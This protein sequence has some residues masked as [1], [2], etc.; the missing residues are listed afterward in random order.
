MPQSGF[1]SLAGWQCE[2]YKFSDLLYLTLDP[3][4][5][6]MHISICLDLEQWKLKCQWAPTAISEIYFLN[7]N[8]F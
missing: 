3:W 1:C 2:E 6:T 7:D 5:P 4:R 8:T